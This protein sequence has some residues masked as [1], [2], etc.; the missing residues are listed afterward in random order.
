MGRIALVTGGAGFV[1][2]HLAERLVA[3]GWTVRALDVREPH[4]DAPVEWIEADVRDGDAVRRAASGVRAV[5]HL[6]TVVG[7]DR[8][9]DDPVDAVDVTVNGTRHALEAAAA[10][11]AALIHLST[12]EVLGSN[13]DLPWA[14][15]ADRRLGSALV[16]RWS[17]AAAKAAAEHVVLA[18]ASRR[19]VPATIIRP[20]NVYGPRQEPRFVVPIMVG[21]ALRGEPIPVHDDGRQTRCF[22]YVSDV[23]EAL[24]LAGEKPGLGR[25]FH[26]GTSEEI[27]MLDLAELVAQLAGGTGGIRFER[28]ADRWGD[29]YEDIPRRVP[30]SSSALTILGWRPTVALRDGLSTTIDWYRAHRADLPG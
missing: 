11:R 1:G 8:L 23:V 28:P 5:F 13:P 9:L 30:D 17:Y 20:F 19:G 26:V 7:V 12:S 6:A 2:G 24:V 3:D 27:S 10:E 22:T 4:L 29:D 25:L 15:D 21:A 18:G 16:D 14:E